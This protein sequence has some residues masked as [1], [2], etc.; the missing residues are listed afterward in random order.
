MNNKHLTLLETLVA[1]AILALVAAFILPRVAKAQPYFTNTTANR[2]P[3]TYQDNLPTPLQPSV[4]LATQYG[5]GLLAGLCVSSTDGTVTNTF[6]TNIFS[7]PPIIVFS[8]A[9]TIHGTNAYVASVTTSNFVI[10][11]GLAAV[12]NSWIAIGH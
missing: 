10:N 3:Y 4:K 6:G 7:T 11:A 1:V 9:S 8:L 12:T 5:A 2:L